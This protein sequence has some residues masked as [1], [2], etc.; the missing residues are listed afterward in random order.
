MA[1]FNIQFEA[2]VIESDLARTLRG[3]ISPVTTLYYN[4]VSAMRG[5]R[6]VMIDAGNNYDIPG[7][8]T[9]RSCKEENVETYESYS[10]LLSTGFSRP[11]GGL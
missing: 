9:P 1:Q 2:V 10:C 4:D 3:K 11:R 8:R 5:A 6:I 7:N